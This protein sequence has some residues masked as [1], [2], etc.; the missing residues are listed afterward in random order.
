MDKGKPASSDFPGITYVLA[1]IALAVLVGSRIVLPSMPSPDVSQTEETHGTTTVFLFG[2]WAL[3]YYF[4]ATTPPVGRS[5]NALLALGITVFGV[6]TSSAAGLLLL[7]F[8][9]WRRR[10]ARILNAIMEDEAYAAQPEISAAPV[11]RKRKPKKANLA[12]E[13]TPGKGDVASR[14]KAETIGRLVALAANH[15]SLTAPENLFPYLNRPK[16]EQEMPTASERLIENWPESP[17]VTL[18]WDAVSPSRWRRENS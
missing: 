17:L 13:R 11:R 5:S 14:T 18:G 16:F 8:L 10:S 7:P 12:A 3:A 1:G 9:W 2:I 4:V 6:I 15:G